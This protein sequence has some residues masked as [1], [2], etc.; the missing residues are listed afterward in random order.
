MIS[1]YLK[2]VDKGT[3]TKDDLLG[4]IMHLFIAG[5]DT[6]SAVISIC[7]YYLCTYP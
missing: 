5:K 7:C 1:Q 3:F 6:S 4:D 2:I